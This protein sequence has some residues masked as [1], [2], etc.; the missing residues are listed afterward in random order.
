M[1]Q[2]AKDLLKKIKVIAI[3]VFFVFVFFKRGDS[4]IFYNSLKAGTQSKSLGPASAH[5]FQ[6]SRP[7]IYKVS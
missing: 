3:Y 4:K 7:S 2:C 1:K 5:P 6:D